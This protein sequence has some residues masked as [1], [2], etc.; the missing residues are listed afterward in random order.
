MRLNLYS[1]SRANIQQGPDH[2]IIQQLNIS[3]TMLARSASDRR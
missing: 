3:R 1:C 2:R